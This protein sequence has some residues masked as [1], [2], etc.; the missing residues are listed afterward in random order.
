[1]IAHNPGV[2][3]LVQ[4]LVPEAEAGGLGTAALCSM[5]F[6]TPHWTAI[7][8]AAVQDVLRETPPARGLFGLFG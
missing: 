7:G 6:E 3:E 4:Q 5:A 1:V 2:S 8:V